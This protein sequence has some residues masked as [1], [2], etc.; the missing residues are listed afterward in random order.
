MSRLFCGDR[1]SVP[2]SGHVDPMPNP[3]GA[4]MASVP[5]PDPPTV[6]APVAVQVEPVPSMVTV[7]LASAAEA[8]F[9]EPVLASPPCSTRANASPPLA[10][11]RFTN[12]VLVQLPV[13]PLT[14]TAEGV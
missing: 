13:L 1:V 6:T 2:P 5:A 7:P 12:D 4:V 8:M 3:P 14:M 9:T 11:D 10:C